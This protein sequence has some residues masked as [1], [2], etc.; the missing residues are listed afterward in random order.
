MAENEPLS[1]ESLPTLDELDAAQALHDAEVARERAEAEAKAAEEAR[2]RARA[3][4]MAALHGEQVAE[5]RG[6]HRKIRAK[7]AAGTGKRMTESEALRTEEVGLAAELEAAVAQFKKAEEYLTEAERRIGGRPGT[8]LAELVKNTL[9]TARKRIAT[10][11]KPV[12]DLEIRLWS[13]RERQISP[14]EAAE[15]RGLQSEMAAV[16][17]RIREIGEV[18]E[19]GPNAWVMREPE[20]LEALE[21]EAKAEGVMRQKV[22]EV[23]AREEG[24]IRQESPRAEIMRRAIQRFIT[25]EIDR[26]GINA[27]TDSDA[28]EAALRELEDG[29]TRGLRENYPDDKSRKLQSDDQRKNFY[30]GAVLRVLTVHP[31]VIASLDGYLSRSETGEAAPPG[32]ERRSEL[33]DQEIARRD[34]Q[35]MDGFNQ[36]LGHHIDTLNFFRAYAA[37]IDEN[38]SNVP[39]RMSAWNSATSTG[40]WND[41]RSR[42]FAHPGGPILP[43]GG[44][45]GQEAF[46]AA[47]DRYEADREMARKMESEL[48]DKDIASYTE[49][50][51]EEER[52]LRELQE[53]AARIKELETTA[54]PLDKYN[55]ITTRLSDIGGPIYGLTQSK[56]NAEY[57]LEHLGG[58]HSFKR[59][60]YK[61]QIADVDAEIKRREAEMAPLQKRQDD[62]RRAENELREL[63]RGAYRLGG[64]IQE[65]EQR[66]AGLRRQIEELTK[67]HAEKTGSTAPQGK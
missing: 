2:K 7:D 24:F 41:P 62:M 56:R 1:A 36:A 19:K 37:E 16:L 38:R 22:L 55:S 30:S 52:L 60:Q 54:N 61:K 20:A 15:Y 9:S 34:T 57:Q 21:D 29:I 33:S 67:K 23:I 12:T 49:A 59:R 8:E 27:I 14:E 3:A 51:E 58:F 28:R 11:Q 53:K 18:T 25:E 63:Q 44:A 50:L 45:A 26:R 42:Y 64:D 4:P 40:L 66:V 43:K 5:A 17:A 6:L 46:T 39:I 10:L 31:G 35:Q 47:N 13:V 32:Y 65:K 48:L